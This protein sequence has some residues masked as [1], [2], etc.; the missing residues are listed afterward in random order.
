VNA[1]GYSRPNSEWARRGVQ[2]HVIS[3][4]LRHSSLSTSSHYVRIGLDEMREAV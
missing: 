3:A 2:P 1:S 4:L